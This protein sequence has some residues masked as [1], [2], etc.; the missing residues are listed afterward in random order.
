[1]RT[2]WGVDMKVEEICLAQLAA[3]E[4]AIV[5]AVETE[6]GLHHRLSEMGLIEG[7]AVCC[8]L[9]A[10]GG[11]PIAYAVRGGTIALRSADAAKIRA[12]YVP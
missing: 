6:A 11:S 10:A 4:N 5:T 3:E 8:V 2:N 12:R 7:T 9:R 1:M